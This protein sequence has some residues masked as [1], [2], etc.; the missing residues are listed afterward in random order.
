MRLRKLHALLSCTLLSLGTLCHAAYP[1]KA[2]TLVVPY[3]PGGSPDILARGVCSV[4]SADMGQP[5]LVDNRP[6]AGTAIGNAYVSRSRPDGYTLLLNTNSFTVVSA[7]SKNPGYNGVD[8]FTPLA[9]L[10]DTPNVILVRNDSPFKTTA[11]LIAAGRAN[12][13]KIN[14]GSP[15]VA[16][17]NQLAAEMLKT[18]GNF[19]MTHVP[20]KGSV[21]QV[22]DVIGGNLDLAF[23]SLPSGMPFIKGG[24]VRALA[25]TSANRSPLLPDVP[26]V[27]ESGL[28]GYDVPAWYGIYGPP[29][30]PAPI[31]DRLLKAMGS[32]V[33]DAR[34]RQWA[35]GEGVALTVKGPEFLGP[36]IHKEEAHWRQVAKAQNI[37]VD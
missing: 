6:G 31:V 2:I 37:S 13:G 9:Y 35:A 28:P 3:V 8:A 24:K 5:C 16:T 19:Q 25:V 29:G 7:L 1:D 33:T 10:G 30:M 34:V 27:A 4:L 32:V 20:Y 23:V 17:L 11:D 36:L 12:P 15:G 18:M 26:T 14:F 22:T 21:P